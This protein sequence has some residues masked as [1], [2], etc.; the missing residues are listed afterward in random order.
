M[1]GGAVLYAKGDVAGLMMAGA[2]NVTSGKL[3]GAQLVGAVNI[4]H[5]GAGVQASGRHNLSREDTSGAQIAGGANIATRSFEGTQIASINIAESASGA[6]I[7]VINIARKVRG[8]QL[9]IVNIAEEVDGAAIGMISVSKGGIHPIVWGSNLQYMN[10]G[11]KFATKHAY[12]LAAVHY[13]TIEGSFDNVGVTAAIGGTSRSPLTSTSSFKA[14]CPIS[15]LAQARA[16]RAETCGGLLKS[17]QATRSPRTFA[18]SR[19]VAGEATTTSQIPPRDSVHDTPEPATSSSAGA[20][21][22]SD[23]N[24]AL[25]AEAHRRHFVERD[26]HRALAAW[27]RYLAAAP[28]GRFVPEARYNRALTLVRMGRNVEAKRGLELFANGMYGPYRQDEAHALL[29]ALDRDLAR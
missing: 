7:G 20:T 21:A 4:A 14:R 29:D 9:G 17:S 12:T 5:G 26:P 25:F 15:S 22:P 10:A 24:A 23:P 2:V 28:N 16:P 27:D 18:S 19:A 11:I 8:T 1:L 3:D 13:G 6:Q